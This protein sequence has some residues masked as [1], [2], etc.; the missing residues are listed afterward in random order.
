MLT[1]LGLVVGLPMVYILLSSL[2][3]DV[4]VASGRLLPSRLTFGNW[5][6]MWST[7]D[8]A[9]GLGNSLLVCGIVAVVSA[10]LG[11]ATAYTLVRF[12]FVGRLTFLR[13]LVVLQSVPGTLL[14]L[15]L[16]VL[17][18]TVKSHLAIAV[19]GTRWGLGVTYLTFALP[20]A[21]WVLVTY[22]RGLPE[23]LEEAGRIDG[24]SRFGV[25]RHIVFPLS[26]PGLVV[27]GIFSFLLGWNDVLFSSVFTLPATRTVAVQLQVFGLSQE[28]GALPLY[29][30][31]M[32]SAVLCALPVVVLYLVFQRQLVAGLTSG[33]VK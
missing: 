10:F 20:F 28:G 29:G 17:F 7:V 6:A 32:S 9:R 33:G 14:L 19:I 13:S 11:L 8:L 24:L 4:D 26:R 1:V 27:A 3:P 12:T 18:A 22:V 15:P 23:A 31:V 25:L 21:T 30:Q 5:V 2:A 16:F